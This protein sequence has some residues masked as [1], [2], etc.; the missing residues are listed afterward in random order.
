MAKA[1]F[2]G[3]QQKPVAYAAS[4]RSTL[5]REPNRAQIGILRRFR[6]Y[7]KPTTAGRKQ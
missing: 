2:P 7:F 6:V 5:Q 1:N 4:E 3:G